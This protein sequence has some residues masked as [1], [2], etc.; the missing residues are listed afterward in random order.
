[1]DEKS[2]LLKRHRGFRELTDEEIQQIAADCDLLE[3][4]TGHVLHRAGEHLKVLY[5]VVEAG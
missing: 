5:L 2:I 3:L 1:M 4:E